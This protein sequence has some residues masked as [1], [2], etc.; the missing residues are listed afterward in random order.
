MPPRGPR[1][2]SAYPL[3]HTFKLTS[4]DPQDGL[5]GGNL[6]QQESPPSNP[7]SIR[8]LRPLGYAMR[9]AQVQVID[10]T[11]EASFTAQNPSET[12]AAPRAA[13][14]STEREGSP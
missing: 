9:C 1:G 11:K 3:R 7:I 4:L 2:L 12:R 14:T 8:L 13:P 10:P 6:L 5:L